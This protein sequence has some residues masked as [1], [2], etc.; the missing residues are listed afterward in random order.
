MNKSIKSIEKYIEE[1][2]NPSVYCKY[3][4]KKLT[5]SESRL[6]GFGMVC[7]KKHKQTHMKKSLIRSEDEI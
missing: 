6:R 4:G 3:C 2:L 5:T 7:Y 1:N